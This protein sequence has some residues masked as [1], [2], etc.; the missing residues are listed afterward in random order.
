[1]K[2]LF[3]VLLIAIGISSCSKDDDKSSASIVG[4]WEYFK[5]FENGVETENE[6]L[7]PTKKDYVHFKENG[8]F[9]D[10]FFDEDC[11][12]SVW[13]YTGTYEK[14][15]NTLI[16]HDP[17][18]GDEEIQIITLNKTTLKIKSAD[19]LSMWTFKRIN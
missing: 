17:D 10:Q 1:M 9:D 15:G 2:Q 3:I 13:S 4:K 6:H 11:S 5:Y 14:E 12:L 7:C 8:T 16:I 19:E 18:F